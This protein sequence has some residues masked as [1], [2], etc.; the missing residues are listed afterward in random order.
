M[1]HGLLFECAGRAEKKRG[2]YLFAK[3]SPRVSLIFNIIRLCLDGCLR[4]GE[5]GNGYAEG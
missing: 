1:R 2:K 4:G 3:Y 5:A